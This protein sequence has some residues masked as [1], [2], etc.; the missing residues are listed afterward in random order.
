MTDVMIEEFIK[1]EIIVP[2]QINEEI[3]QEWMDE[4]KA[5]AEKQFH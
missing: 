1:E 3:W 4:F 2:T 5:K